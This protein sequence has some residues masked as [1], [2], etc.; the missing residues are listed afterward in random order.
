MGYNYEYVTIQPQD[1]I[2]YYRNELKHTTML[3]LQHGMLHHR[4]LRNIIELFSEIKKLEE[5]KP[6][7][8][9]A[10]K[11]TIAE[12]EERLALMESLDCAQC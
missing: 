1:C 12:R 9:K 5:I 6:S 10:I 7:K 11:A 4:Q 8:G 3:S 2:A